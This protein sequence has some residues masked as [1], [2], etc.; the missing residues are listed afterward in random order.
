MFSGNANGKFGELLQGSL[1]GEDNHF[2][3]SVP[4]NRYVTAKFHCLRNTD[5][6]NIYPPHKIKSASLAF[7]IMRYFGLTCGW[8]LN[9][10]SELAEGKGLGSSTADLVACARAI[11]N[12]TGKKLPMKA[13]LSFLK[14]IE[15]S[16]GVMYDGLV[17]FFYRRV[18][19]YEQLGF[20]PNLAIAGI[21]EGGVIDTINFNN[22]LRPYTE[23]EKEKYSNLLEKILVAIKTED[24][25]TIGEVSTESAIL[26]QSINPK[27]YLDYFLNIAETVGATG[28]V[29][30][31]SGTYMGI[32]MNTSNPD[33]REKL[34]FIG[35]KASERSLI[36]ENFEMPTAAHIK[37]FT[38]N[39]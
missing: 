31:H 32:I 21:D 26:H 19:L 14:E 38:A 24:L 33:Y 12:A 23:L 5:Q 13:F 1:P 17:C 8:E 7:K 4:I 28:I 27:K 11:E 9:L 15:P 2:L 10:E 36:L 25:K 29:V 6:A 16:D 39:V 34:H 30:A 37:K 22:H 35:Q 3:I 18:A 20:L